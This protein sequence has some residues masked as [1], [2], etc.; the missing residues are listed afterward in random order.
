MN[1]PPFKGLYGSERDMADGSVVLADD[2]YL[3][4]SILRP[5]AKTVKGYEAA[6]PS[7]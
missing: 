3:K 2:A 6:M 4:E 7:F 1:G 5:E